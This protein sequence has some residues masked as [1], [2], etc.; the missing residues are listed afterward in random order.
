M[1]RCYR[2]IRLLLL[3][4]MATQIVL[5]VPVSSSWAKDLDTFDRFRS[6]PYLDRAYRAAAHENWADVEKLM[7]H[8]LSLVPENTEARHLI[9]QAQIN[10]DHF[11]DALDSA[12]K[13]PDNAEKTKSFRMC[14][15]NGLKH[16]HPP[17]ATSAPG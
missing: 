11:A 8:L 12:Q 7:A 5:F 17:K 13:L 15:L 3:A 6:Y 4:F 10:Q 1:T 16:H 9:I 14:A 2:K